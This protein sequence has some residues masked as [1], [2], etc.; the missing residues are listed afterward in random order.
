L[1]ST[2][3]GSDHHCWH[4]RLRQ[5]EPAAEFIVC[6]SASSERGFGYVANFILDGLDKHNAN[7]RDRFISIHGTRREG[8]IG[9]PASHAYM[10]MRNADVVELFDL[11]DEGVHVLIEE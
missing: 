11:V 1:C 6:R 10:R 7:R 9:S 2:Q 4:D 3:G 8:N 5:I